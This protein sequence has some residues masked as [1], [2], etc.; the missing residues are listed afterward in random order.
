MPYGVTGVVPVTPMLQLVIRLLELPDEPPLPKLT[1]P[2]AAPAVAVVFPPTIL[3][4]CITLCVASL[5]NMKMGE[6]FTALVFEMV[7]FL[8][9]VPL[10][11]LNI[12]QLL[13]V[14]WN[15]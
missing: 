15:K 13:P 4:F 7:R 5:W 11:P 3:Q 12:N 6:A 8:G 14:N 1:T 10:L 9:A 2:Q